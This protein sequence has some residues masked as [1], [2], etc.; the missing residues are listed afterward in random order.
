MK[1][2]K[3]ASRSFWPLLV[4]ILLAF[5]YGE[6]MTLGFPVTG[7]PRL[8]GIIGVLLGLYAAS[9][10]AANMLDL[11]FFARDQLRAGMSGRAYAA[12]WG[13]NGLVLLAGWFS[14]TSG[15]IRF[16]AR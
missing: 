16:S 4:L 9:H 15:L 12:W 14:I 2:K 1:A 13:I 7:T 10:P 3:G 11:L 8:D 5:A 6:V